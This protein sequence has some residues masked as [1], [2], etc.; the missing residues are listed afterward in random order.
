MALIR[1]AIKFLR[2]FETQHMVNLGQKTAILGHWYWAQKKKNHPI[3]TKYHDTK[4]VSKKL[5]RKKLIPKWYHKNCQIFNL[6]L[7]ILIWEVSLRC[8]EIISDVVKDLK[9]VNI[10]L[11]REN[12]AIIEKKKLKSPKM[13]SFRVMKVSKKSQN[14]RFFCFPKSP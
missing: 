3:Q 12:E 9:I 14:P 13:V 5:T 10:S 11:T 4:K 8:L 6:R 2:L 1:V 7:I